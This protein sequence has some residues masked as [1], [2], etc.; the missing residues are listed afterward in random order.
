MAA[1]NTASA[2]ARWTPLVVTAAVIAAA[3]ATAA[4][5]ARPL[6]GLPVALLAGMSALLGRALTRDAVTTETIAHL[7]AWLETIDPTTQ[8]AVIAAGA[9]AVARELSGACSA[10]LVL[11]RE[12]L[13]WRLRPG[14]P[15]EPDEWEPLPELV[16]QLGAYAEIADG[17]AVVRIGRPHNETPQQ[18]QRRAE[19]LGDTPGPALAVP[20]HG[21]R[22]RGVLVVADPFRRRTGAPS[23][24]RASS[25]VWSAQPPQEPGDGPTPQWPT[26]ARF[27]RAVVVRLRLLAAHLASALDM[28]LVTQHVQE[29]ARRQLRT[30]TTDTLTGLP[31]RTVF[32]E[33]V[34]AAA[35]MSSSKLLVAVLLVNLDRFREINATFGHHIGDQLLRQFGARMRDALPV[36]ATVARLGGDEFAAL[37]CELSDI[38]A[39]RRIAEELLADLAVPYAVGGADLQLEASMGVALAPLHAEDATALLQRADIA[40]EGAKSAHRG[41]EIYDPA[42]GTHDGSHL[43]MLVDLRRAIDGD[44]LSIVYQPKAGLRTHAVSGVEALLRWQHPTRGRIPPGEFIPIAER[45]GLIHP[46]TQ[47][48]LQTVMAQQRTWR[49]LGLDIEVAV[50][51]SARN[52][53]DESLPA[54]IAMLLDEY[55]LPP[56]ALRLEITESSLIVDPGRAEAVIAELHHLGLRLS[57]D[58]FGTGYSSLAHLLRLPVD[59]IKVDRTFVSGLLARRNEAA[60]VHAT[61]DLGRRLAITVTA[62]GV[63]DHAT[64]AK[65]A[66]MGC[67]IA[68]GF[69][70]ARPMDAA[71][72]ER[73]LHDFRPT[74]PHHPDTPAPT[75]V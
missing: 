16:G 64:W 44:E 55:G 37:L 36:T 66:D 62:E 67:D 21:S 8:T 49:A 22:A 17:S 63:E 50:N 15:G 5:L 70:F 18:R 20:F 65:L 40:M 7:D 4:I 2:R 35:R 9:L 53:L 68:Q 42:G 57:V 10:D 39:V 25:V 46:L 33:R 41:A 59:E 1:T 24:S 14:D 11:F 69:W 23:W 58:D 75:A 6:W 19:L 31:N 43:Q 47:W 51:L 54:Q 73:W 48:V 29:S 28:S 26:A 30:A 52:L 3:A 60:I 74:G 12:G 71:A 27:P 45:T 56:H 72:L 34:D 61:I 13:G 38:R 32:V